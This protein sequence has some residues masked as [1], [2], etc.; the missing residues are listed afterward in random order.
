MK[1]LS[2][3]GL[4]CLLASLVTGVTGCQLYF[5]EDGSTRDG[6]CLEDGYYVGGEWV[7]AECPGGGNACV[8]NAECA[9]G[10]YCNMEKSTCDEGGFCSDVKDCPAGYK[11]DERSS[12][13]PDTKSCAGAIAPTCTNGAPRC[14][15]GQVPLI[16]NGCYV[17]ATGDGQFD[18]MAIGECPAPATCE[19]YQYTPD[20]QAAGCTTVLRGEDCRSQTGGTTCQDGQLGC[21]CARY[22][23]SRCESM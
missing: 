6:V 10:C 22:V 2:F 19:A 4:L 17:D 3:L 21:V 14:P 5:G 23:F 15:Q 8:T 20:C 18:C 9:A 12:C 11:C 7:S 1:K 13:V 16:E